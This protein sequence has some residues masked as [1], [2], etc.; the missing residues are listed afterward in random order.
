MRTTYGVK[1]L[2]SID[3]ISIGYSN[4]LKGIE[5]YGSIAVIDP[6]V[7]TNYPVIAHNGNNYYLRNL[8]DPD[9]VIMIVGRNEKNV[10]GVIIDYNVRT[11]SGKE[12]VLAEYLSHFRFSVKNICNGAR[13]VITTN[14]PKAKYGKTQ[15]NLDEIILSLVMYGDIRNIKQRVNEIHHDSYVWDLR[16]KNMRLVTREQHMEIHRE[17]SHQSHSRPYYITFKELEDFRLRKVA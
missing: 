10:L 7:V 17:I 12:I 3:E 8:K 2:E 13:A 15:M 11:A 1:Y 16:V 9:T 5:D 6:L 4:N 14:C